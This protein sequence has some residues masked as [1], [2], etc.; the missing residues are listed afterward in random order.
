[1]SSQLL[2]TSAA[3]RSPLYLVSWASR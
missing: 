2:P 3:G 1:M